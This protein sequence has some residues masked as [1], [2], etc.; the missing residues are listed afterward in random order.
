M[1]NKLLIKPTLREVCEI[2]SKENLV[3][4]ELSMSGG[5]VTALLIEG[6][7]KLE[8]T[9]IEPVQG[10]N[11]YQLV[12]QINEL[13]GEIEKMMPLNGGRNIFIVRYDKK[14]HAQRVKE[15]SEAKEKALKEA[16]EMA[17]NEELAKLDAEMKELKAKQMS[18]RTPAMVEA[19]RLAK[20]EAEKKA[21]NDK[22]K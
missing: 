15:I 20:E 17:R 10:N 2:A 11:A 22:G 7:E 3:M 14:V 8:N 13:G 21:K 6:E 5:T 12:D 19:E 18:L 4:K 1:K 16:E 9:F